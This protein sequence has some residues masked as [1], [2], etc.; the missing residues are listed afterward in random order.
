MFS[1][2]KQVCKEKKGLAPNKNF[3]NT[4]GEKEGNL[5]GLGFSKNP[6]FQQVWH[7]VNMRDKVKAQSNWHSKVS[8][9]K[10]IR[11]S[12]TSS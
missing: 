7:Q 2:L 1:Y 9:G 8:P 6:K 12:L 11:M 4:F 10:W 5:D 3:R